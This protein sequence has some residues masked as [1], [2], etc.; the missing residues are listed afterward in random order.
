MTVRAIKAY[1]DSLIVG[2]NGCA[3]P[4]APWETEKDN[5]YS[6]GLIDEMASRKTPIDFF[7]WHYYTDNTDLIVRYPQIR[8]KLD[9]VGNPCPSTCYRMEHLY[10]CMEQDTVSGAA[11][12]VTTMINMIQNRVNWQRFILHV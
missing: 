3:L 4:Y 7:S 6:W 12:T 10:D 5:P 1:D 8:A 9:S 2:A 11:S